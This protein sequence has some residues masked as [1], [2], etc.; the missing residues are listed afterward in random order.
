MYNKYFKLIF[1]IFLCKTHYNINIMSFPNVS[2]IAYNSTLTGSKA[3]R[4]LNNSDYI[5]KILYDGKQNIMKNYCKLYDSAKKNE[6]YYDVLASQISMINT[7]LFEEY[8]EYIPVNL[9]ESGINSNSFHPKQEDPLVF[10]MSS[11]TYNG[12]EILTRTYFD[13]YLNYKTANHIYIYG[14]ITDLIINDLEIIIKNT[15]ANNKQLYIHV[16]GENILDNQGNDGDTIFGMES[17]GN[18]F[19][20]AFNYQ[21]SMTNA[22]KLRNIIQTNPNCEAFTIKSKID[23]KLC[24]SKINNIE[25]IFPLNNSGISIKNGLP[26]IYVKF[27]EDIT[28]LINGT[29]YNNKTYLTLKINS[30]YQDMVDKDNTTSILFLLLNS[31]NI[32]KTNVYLIGREAFHLTHDDIIVP[33]YQSMNFSALPDKIKPVNIDEQHKNIELNMGKTNN[34]YWPAF[35]N[36]MYDLKYDKNLSESHYKLMCICFKICIN[37]ML[38]MYDITN[39][40][41][42]IM[43]N[44]LIANPSNNSD[45]LPLLNEILFYPSLNSYIASINNN[46]DYL[47]KYGKLI[48][49]VTNSSTYLSTIELSNIL[50]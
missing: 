50:I 18:L 4:A 44:N 10:K 11:K 46:S 13:N 12:Y 47:S 14:P 49:S 32:N 43:N 37:S 48:C 27:Y 33:H 23:S 29:F 22:R 15:I 41:N 5:Q 30:I 1:L 28:K 31:H 35:T 19:K 20:N 39:Y 17:K 9:D 6:P 24:V 26:Y 21:N 34:Y 8:F 40:N 36:N 7:K 16:Q 2:F 3:L 42:Y 45:K 38:Y 25:L